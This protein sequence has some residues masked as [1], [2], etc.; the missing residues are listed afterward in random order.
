MT[1]LDAEPWPWQPDK[2][3]ADQDF[4]DWMMENKREKWFA[5]TVFHMGPGAHHRVP[6]TC[7]V[8]G[9]QCISITVSEEEHFILPTLDEYQCILQNIWDVNVLALPRIDF[10]TL[11]HVGEEAGKWGDIDHGK[12]DFLIGRVVQGGYIFFYTR[13]AAWDRQMEYLNWAIRSGLMRRVKN[14]KNLVMF[15]KS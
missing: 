8:L 2:C 15:Q 14:Y 9:L 7:N 11:F 4:I 3:P 13:S 1:L 5:G 12:L 10:M 6:R